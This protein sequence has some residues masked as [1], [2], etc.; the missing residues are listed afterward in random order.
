MWTLLMQ[1]KLIKKIKAY[2][3]KTYLGRIFS[4]LLG[5]QANPEKWVFIIGCYNS[6]TTLLSAVLSKHPDISTLPTEG[7]FIANGMATPES[8]GWVRMWH[9]CV[10]KIEQNNQTSDK[11]M[12]NIK[13][14]WGFWFNKKKSVYLEK[15]ISNAVR[16]E[17]LEKNFQPAYFIYIVRNGYAVSEGIRR[18]SNLKKWNVPLS[19]DEYPIELCA[20]QWVESDKYVSE[21]TK[22]VKNILHISYEELVQDVDVVLSKICNFIDI[23]NEPLKNIG[24][25]TL[26]VVGYQSKIKNMNPSSIDRLTEEDI[27]AI[28]HTAGEQLKKNGYELL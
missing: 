5:K 6:G 9:K 26:D 17:F 7:A 12:K 13:S 23:P 11:N 15:S 8:F 24:Q 1:A 27:K 4:S 10:D 3:A 2:Y 19:M 21:K 18:K 22:Y 25:E 14:S 16:I 20:Q 28:N